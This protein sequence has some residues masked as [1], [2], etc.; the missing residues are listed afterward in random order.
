V[1][2]S[3]EA[4]ADTAHLVREFRGRV[5]G[6]LHCFSGGS[7][8]LDVGLEAGWYVGFAGMV[9]FRGFQGRDLLR[10]VPSDRLL[11]ET[12]SPYLAPVPH[13]GK[14]NEPAHVVRVAEV[15]AQL[16]DEPLDAVARATAA[17]AR[18]LYGL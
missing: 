3:R 16:R 10:T 12:D 11:I 18:T 9:S 8:L 2:H 6:V 13:R 5:V 14:R 17:N 4:D 15:V 7:E 1:V